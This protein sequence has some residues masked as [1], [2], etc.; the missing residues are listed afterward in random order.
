MI[1]LIT[2]TAA[3]ILILL[4]RN[5]I[6]MRENSRQKTLIQ[7]G[8]LRAVEQLSAAA[9][10]INS[11]LEKQLYSAEPEQQSALAEKLFN[12]A[13][14]AKAAMAELPIQKLSLENTY[15]FLSQVGNYAR[16]IAEKSAAGESITEEEY[17]NLKTLHEFA[18]KL[19]EHMWEIEKAI[20]SR[21]ISIDDISEIDTDKGNSLQVSEDFTEFEEGFESY[22]TLIYDGPF[23]DHIMEKEPIATKDKPEI[24]K[25]KALERAS[26]ILNIASTDLS[27]VTEQ[28]SRMPSWVFSDKDST[29]SCSVTKNGGYVS[30]F[31]KSRQPV[32]AKLSVK[33]AVKEAENFLKEHN[34]NNMKTTYYERS[35]NVVTVNFA[36][37]IDGIIC[38]TDLVKVTTALD[39]GE[40]LG[41]EAA[42]YLVN[43]QKRAFPDSAVSIRDCEKKLSPYLECVDR[44]RALIPTDGSEEVYCYEFRCE[45]EDD[46]QV[47]VYMNAETGKEEQILILLENENGTLAI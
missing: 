10:N 28:D 23:S 31:L 46:R 43:H 19:S 14:A 3:A 24:S 40:I 7:T 22:P 34:Y 45:A 32:T 20:S 29:V 15:K 11:T 26:M 6:L 13:A 39:D 38:Y 30:Y 17:N 21:E 1:R 41:F 18:K 33:Q 25:T 8:Y 36:Y 42:G 47:L 2:F 27:N 16:A 44:G 35:G 4:T 12:E 37:E 5:I 9:D